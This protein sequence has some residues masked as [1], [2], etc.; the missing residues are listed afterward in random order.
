MIE[1]IIFRPTMK[2]ALETWR[3]FTEAAKENTEAKIKRYPPQIITKRCRIRF[4]SDGEQN[5]GLRADITVPFDPVMMSHS[6]FGREY[7]TLTNILQ[8]LKQEGGE[9]WQQDQKEK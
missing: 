2:R 8:L 4:R 9:I 6:Q 5:M 7:C 3:T 1:I